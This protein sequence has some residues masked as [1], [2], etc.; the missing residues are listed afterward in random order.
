MLNYDDY[1]SFS[2]LFRDNLKTIHH[3]SLKLFGFEPYYELEDSK[4]LN[5]GFLKF[6]TFTHVSIAAHVA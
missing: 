2:D 1:Y 4:F 3:L 6:G 5:S